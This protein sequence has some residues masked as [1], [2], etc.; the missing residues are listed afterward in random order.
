W[1]KELVDFDLSV[2]E[3]AFRLTDAGLEVENIATLGTNLNGVVVGEIKKVS[4]HPQA[5]KLS[6]CLVSVGTEDLQ[7]VCGAPNVKEKAKVPVALIDTRLPSGVKISKSNL[8][9]VESFGMICS[10]MELEI[11]EDAE[12]IM[13][14]DPKLKVG[15]PISSA[16]ELEDHILDIAITPN[17]PDWLSMI[18]VAREVAALCGSRV[19]NSAIALKETN[20]MA[21][22]MVQVEIIDAT[23][24]PRYAAR[25]I[26]EIRIS[27][28]PFWLKRKLQSAGMRSINNVVDVTN[29]VMLELGHPLHA[30][31]YNLFPQKKVVVRRAKEGEKFVTLDQVERTLNQEVLLITNGAKAV[32]IGGIMGGLESEVTPETRTVLLESAYF[33]PKVIRR[34][35]MFL[36]LSTESS[37]R[38]ERGAD[39]NGV[40]KAMDRAA[41]LL[42]DL[43][44][45]EVLKGVVDNYP[46]VIQP[47]QVT[48]RPK[49]VNRILSTDLTP[50]QIKDILTHLEIPVREKADLEVEVPTFRPDL[51]REIDLIEEIA[52]IYGY[53][54][55]KTDMRAGGSLVTEINREDEILGEIKQF[56]RGKGFFEV[57][58]NNLVDPD[59]LKRLNP[60]VPAIEIKNPLSRDLSVLTTT[61]AYNSLSV[62]SW[63]KNRLERNIRIFELG[64]VFTASDSSYPQEKHHL[65]IALSGSRAPR[66]WETKETEV[67]LYDLKGDL[68]ELLGR[69]SLSI[70]LVPGSHILFDPDNCFMVKTG[71]DFIGLMGGISKEIS[72]LFEIKDKVLWAELDV[73]KMISRVPPMKE[74]SPLPKFPPVD[75][76]IAVVVDEEL[77]SK[78]I[79][80]QIKET[81]GDLVEE[82][83]L[84]D[85]YSGKQI[86]PGKKSLACSIRY[87][88]PE[89]TLTDEEV[90]DIHRKVILQLEQSFGAALRQ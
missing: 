28:S 43:A 36:D 44:G 61:L 19:K 70:D 45:G 66:H 21:N 12:G 32:A 34:G 7:I 47:V 52:R 57:I 87:R 15:E 53:A 85:V 68:E 69:L 27:A 6:V 37:Q 56:M 78:E 33:D 18:G 9:G 24:C 75:R 8:R 17:R 80:D 54:N 46:S 74:F 16:L 49:R 58:T 73:D 1:L 86:Q 10:E 31:D 42:A 2:E 25:I 29:L 71:D 63:N 67:D 40:I 89:K 84:F 38:F 82:V 79:I 39:P 41:Q 22:D 51:T 60:G 3:L 11:G 88:S 55:I 81:G 4:S 65:G 64:K 59:L 26:E 76:D 62:V 20:R 13:I 83:V 50:Q 5:D 23:G 14:L 30:F 35:R 48:M 90:E 77:L 72:D